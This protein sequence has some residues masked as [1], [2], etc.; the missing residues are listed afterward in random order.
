MLERPSTPSDFARRYSSSF[1]LPS[2]STPPYVCFS[3]LRGLWVGRSLLDLELPVVAPLLRDVLDRRPRGAVR[4]LLGVV[5]LVRAVERLLVGLLHLARRALERAGQVFLLR[6][7]T[8]ALPGVAELTLER[9]RPRRQR[10]DLAPDDEG[11]DAVRRGGL[12][13]TQVRQRR[14]HALG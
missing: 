12:E 13:E 7:H 2:T 8:W 4:A 5:L 14:L 3:G 11:Y 10:C 1:E 9:R 6:W